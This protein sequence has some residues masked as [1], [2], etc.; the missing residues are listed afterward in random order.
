MG[1]IPLYSAPTPEKKGVPSDSRRK[2]YRAR[3]TVNRD[4]AHA[5][6]TS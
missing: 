1:S 3:K 6:T 2:K 4:V 5:I